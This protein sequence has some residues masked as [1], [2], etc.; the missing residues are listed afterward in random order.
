MNDIV[1]L[2]FYSQIK[3][4]L[5]T[6]RSK[7]LT[8]ANF[9]MVEAYWY[10]GKSIVE[11]QGGET[12]AEYGI[13]LLSE[14]SIQLTAD[15]G[16]GFNTVSLRNIRQFYLTFPIRSAV[17]SELSWTHY[18]LL[19]RV[20]NEQARQFYLDECVKSVWSTRQLERQI[21]SFFYERLLSSHNKGEVA[22]EVFISTLFSTIIF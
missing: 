6:A 13:K 1:D 9:A 14:L 19:M 8:V 3:D 10:I 16:K 4:I 20:E 5:A 22:A 2:Q 21:N 18:R 15:F 17:R 7:V 12:R 11:K